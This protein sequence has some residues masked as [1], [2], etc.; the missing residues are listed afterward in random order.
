MDT[1]PKTLGEA[2]EQLRDGSRTDA[3]HFR[4]LA[5]ALEILV[6]LGNRETDKRDLDIDVTDYR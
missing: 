1:K 5:D 2:L 6:L 4:D 3:Q